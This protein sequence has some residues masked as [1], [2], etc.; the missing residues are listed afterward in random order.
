M[1]TRAELLARLSEA[2]PEIALPALRAVLV[3][4]DGVDAAGKT[5]FADAWA[6]QLR[7]DGRPVVR[8]GLDGFL[9][10]RAVRHARGRRSP[11]GFYR[12]SYDLAA[13]GRSV[14]DPLLSGPG[15]AGGAVGIV[16]AVWDHQRDEPVCR[17][18]DPVPEGA[19]VLVDGLFLH[20]PQL[21]AVWDVG[22][23]LDVP[24]EVTFAR[25]AIR[26]GCPP[27]PQHPDNAR[28]RLGQL[29]YLAEANPRERAAYLVDNRDPTRPILRATRDDAARHLGAGA[30]GG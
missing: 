23:W 14:L 16:T 21:A 3:G 2:I 30:G 11:E 5:T 18:P 12:D 27:D 20:R 25:M 22:V 4:V 17:A 13:F 8:V 28:Y 10:P 7:Q 29:I 24:F 26:D 6:D 9:A 19:V 15:E 1:T